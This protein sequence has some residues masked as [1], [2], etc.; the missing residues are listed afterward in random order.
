MA[1][2]LS[3]AGY[4]R[5]SW[6]TK[7]RYGLLFLAG[8]L[9]YCQVQLKALS[10]AYINM[11]SVHNE[12]VTWSSLIDPDVR[13]RGRGIHWICLWNNHSRLPFVQSSHLSTSVAADN[14]SDLVDP[15]IIDRLQSEVFE[16]RQHRFNTQRFSKHPSRGL[17]FDPQPTVHL[18]H[19]LQVLCFGGF[20]LIILL[21]R[22]YHA[23]SILKQ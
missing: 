1:P 16:W 6:S 13:D 7:P 18:D 8:W 2:L 17:L 22:R 3:F 19:R 14:G 10:D 9:M 15:I 23:K 5:S 21:I 20:L 12:M 4:L 11:N